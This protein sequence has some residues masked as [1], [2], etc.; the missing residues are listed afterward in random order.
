MPDN[1]KIV[2]VDD[3]PEVL[4]IVS[5]RLQADGYDVFSSYYGGD[6]MNL[7]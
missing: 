6:V 2:I 5:R 1:Y 3:D 7:I 4:D